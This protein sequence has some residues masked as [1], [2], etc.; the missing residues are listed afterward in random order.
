MVYPSPRMGMV[1]QATPSGIQASPPFQSRLR[2]RHFPTY[3]IHL[4]PD[5]CAH[6]IA[7]TTGRQQRIHDRRIGTQRPQ[8]HLILASR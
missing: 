4:S 3:A 6:Q 2:G 8:C 5:K 1:L 7:E